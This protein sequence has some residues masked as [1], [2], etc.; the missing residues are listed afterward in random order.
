MKITDRHLNIDKLFGE[1]KTGDIFRD[2]D[3]DIMMKI[4]PYPDEKTNC[5]NLEDGEGYVY[6]DD[7]KITLITNIELIVG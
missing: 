4:N 3:G 1:L 5:I 7:E 6:C 2:F